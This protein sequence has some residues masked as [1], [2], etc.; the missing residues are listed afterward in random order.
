MRF[1]DLLYSIQILY[2]CDWSSFLHNHS[3]QGLPRTPSSSLPGGSIKAQ[4]GGKRAAGSSNSTI[5]YHTKRC[6]FF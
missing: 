2:F 4:F 1:G 3:L 6:A 5:P